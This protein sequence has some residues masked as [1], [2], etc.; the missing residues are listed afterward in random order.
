MNFRGWGTR[1][2]RPNLW[3][4]PPNFPGGHSESQDRRYAGW[5]SKRMSVEC[6]SEAFR[7]SPFCRQ[8][9]WTMYPC[10]REI[11]V[12]VFRWVYCRRFGVSCLWYYQMIGVSRG[13]P[14]YAIFRFTD[15]KL[16]T[17]NIFLFLGTC[18]SVGCWAPQATYAP[19]VHSWPN[20]FD[21]SHIPCINEI[22]KM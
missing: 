11:S 8:K 14:L 10:S 7:L 21:I 20:Q 9:R 15:F 2:P 5:Y 4:W 16:L 6:K 18:T 12:T 3:H 13:L 22:H 1:G 17:S 19:I